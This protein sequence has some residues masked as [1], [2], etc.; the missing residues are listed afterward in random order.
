LLT[1]PAAENEKGHDERYNH[2]HRYDDHQQH[3]VAHK[4]S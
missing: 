4:V 1:S 3:R 2:E